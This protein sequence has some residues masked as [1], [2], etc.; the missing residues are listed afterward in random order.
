[1]VVELP[2]QLIKMEPSDGSEMAP[3]QKR[4]LKWTRKVFCMPIKPVADGFFELK[5]EARDAI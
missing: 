2:T 1:M 5:Q 4:E 3:L